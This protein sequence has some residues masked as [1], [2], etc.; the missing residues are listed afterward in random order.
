MSSFLS[1]LILVSP[2]VNAGR[3]IFM[4]DH[5]PENPDRSLLIGRQTSKWDVV[6]HDN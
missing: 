6:F 2:E 1:I 4:V 5:I 3:V